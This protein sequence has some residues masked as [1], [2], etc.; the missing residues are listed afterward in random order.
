M[1]MTAERTLVW[2][3]RVVGGS[4]LLALPAA[5]M[6]AEWM[7]ATHRWLGLGEMPDGPVVFYM[8]RSLSGFYAF[9]SLLLL[10]LSLDVRLYLPLLR[11][12]ALALLPF[13]LGFLV[14]DAAVGMPVWWTCMEG[15]GVVIF[16]G[17]MLWL[18]RRVERGGTRL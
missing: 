14:M 11:F 2:L 18:L 13:G 15:P 4:G 8:A 3:L 1:P 7:R 9:V 12:V 6:P 16:G 17:V 5:L 10:Y